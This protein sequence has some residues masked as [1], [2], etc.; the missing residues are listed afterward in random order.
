MNGP[1]RHLDHATLVGYSAGALPV[2][3]AAVVASHLELCATC[4]AQLAVADAIGARLIEQQEG[5]PLSSP[6]REAFRARL[7]GEAIEPPRAPAPQPQPQSDPDLLPT[8]LRP[9]FG[10]RYSTLRWRTVGPGI[11]LLRA[12]GDAP[13]AQLM[14]LRTAPG[15][16][17]PQHSH[18]NNELT[19][20]LRGAY[21]DV[22][23]HFGPGD[24]ADLDLDT[25]H[26]PVTSPGVPCICVFASDAPMKFSGWIA[27]AM[28][29]VLRI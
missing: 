6:A 21:D 23:G 29:S 15:R 17:M 22:L 7:E 5:A 26:Q 11:H 20:I 25:E 1:V 16:R 8:P 9:W 14:M 19:L 2:A 13:G 27:R 10:D 3:F 12:Q 28:Q 4:R 24:V 18:G